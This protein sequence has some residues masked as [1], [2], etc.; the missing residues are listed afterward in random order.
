MDW[1]VESRVKW[2]YIGPAKGLE[3]LLGPGQPAQT[4]IIE[5]PPNP[6]HAS[7]CNVAAEGARGGF[8]FESHRK[9]TLEHYAQRRRID[10]FTT[11]AFSNNTES[12][13]LAI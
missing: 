13:D 12:S 6:Q 11:M 1:Y 9:S 2:D 7:G 8:R 5:F 10:S 4:A 3:V